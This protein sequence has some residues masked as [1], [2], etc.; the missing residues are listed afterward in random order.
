MDL[1]T[2]R[3]LT[4][5]EIAI[6]F[7][8]AV[9][10]S[11]FNRGMDLPFQ[12]GEYLLRIGVNP[13]DV[14]KEF[15]QANPHRELEFRVAE[16]CW[17]LVG[18]GY[19]VPQVSSGWGVFFPTQRGRAFLGGF[20]PATV[21][22]GGLDARLDEIGF[23][24]DDLSRQYVRLAQDCF[25]TGH[26]E[27]VVVMLGAATESLIQRVA[28][29]LDAAN[30]T[31]SVPVRSRPDRPTARQNLAWLTEFTSVHRL[32]LPKRYRPPDVR[33]RGSRRWL[34]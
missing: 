31:L 27:A 33:A 30:T 1:P 2:N 8:E 19:L 20:D 5:A 34:M 14:P 7:A 26:N 28:E 21:T 4:D 13:K 22:S 18:L 6:G 9:L 12:P 17:R 32:T 3:R 29:A 25:L 16:Y 10:D 11:K 24:S 23:A 15:H